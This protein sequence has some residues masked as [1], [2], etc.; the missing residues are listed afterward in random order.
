LTA[1]FSKSPGRLIDVGGFRLHLNDAGH[2]SPTVVFDAALG[3]SSLSW[4][5]VQ[6][7][8]AAWTRA[9]SYDRAGLGWSD[10]GPLPRT[11]ARHA[12][13]LHELLQRAEAPPPYVLVGHSFGTL[14]AR[15]FAAR[16]RADV[17]GLVLVE[18]AFPEDLVTPGP[19]E[20]KRMRRAVRLCRYGALAARLRLTSSLISGDALSLARAAASFV[21]RRAF[22]RQD[23]ELISPI[24]KLPERERAQLRW[25]WTQPRYFRALASQI[26]SIGISAKQLLEASESLVDM[27]LVVV[28]ATNPH[29]HHVKMQEALVGASPM[30][31]RTVAQSSGHWV[32][33]DDPEAVVGALREVIELVR[34]VGPH[35]S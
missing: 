34:R 26:D 33:L 27:P 2:G 3:G 15:M 9:C 22:Q 25:M 29:P 30:G 28:S 10:A 24:Q 31:R 23:D 1:S 17:K 5:F 16:Y 20:W 6:P 8:V 13:E 19:R 7:E 12:A 14:V 32:P 35:S 18:P 4:C 11:V 21:S